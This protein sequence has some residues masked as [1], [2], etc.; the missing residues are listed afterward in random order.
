[1]NALPLRRIAVVALGLVLSSLACLAASPGRT[2]RGDRTA[3]DRYVAKPDTNYSFR[4][5]QSVKG[6]GYTMHYVDMTSQSWLTTN[7]VNRHLWQH[8]L[9]SVVP[10]KVTT[11]TA[12]LFIGGRSKRT[13]PAG[14]TAPTAMLA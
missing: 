9:T 14:K 2:Q 4:L 6:E 5:E 8:W 3:L 7:E 10:D 11:P 12:L 13:K 1:M